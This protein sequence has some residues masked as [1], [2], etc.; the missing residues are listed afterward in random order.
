MAATRPIPHLGRRSPGRKAE[1]E[2]FE[3]RQKRVRLES[4][5]WPLVLRR[6]LLYV[7]CVSNRD[8]SQRLHI[9]FLGRLMTVLS[10]ELTINNTA[11]RSHI[12][13]IN[14]Y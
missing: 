3:A 1:K 14:N 9:L 11:L 8:P 4:N 6:T 2:I 13:N 12:I 7:N 5:E 10:Q